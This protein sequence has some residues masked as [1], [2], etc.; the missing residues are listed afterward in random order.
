MTTGTRVAFATALAVGLALAAA[1]ALRG[2]G[3]GAALAAL[4]AELAQERQARERLE[5]EVARLAGDLAAFRE[6]ASIGD[7]AA[8]DRGGS[9]PRSGI[10]VDGGAAAEVA[11]SVEDAASVP[12]P[13]Y[14]GFDTDRLRGAGLA[15]RD[16]ADLRRLFE[17]IELDR[18]YL[19]NQASREG[20]PRERI[21]A[22]DAALD[23]RSA[24]V[25]Q[26]YGDETYDWFLYAAG[27]PNRVVVEGVLGGSAAEEA[28]IRRGD[29]ILSY[30]GGRVFR[31][32]PLVQ[33]T[34]RGSLD[35][36]VDVELL[37]GG[38][39][40]ELTLPRGPLGVRLGRRSAQPEP[41]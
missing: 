7:S 36:N 19:Q 10:D 20:W 18:L 3:D 37:R 16:V 13:G 12:S 1:L 22:E 39:R 28:G 40:I 26:T 6:G 24:T 34:I 17:E 14:A 32:G 41:Q 33:G 23:G 8:T 30:D 11:A 5:T 38:E 27:K 15:E 4:R 9:E 29:V 35:E 25:R 21:A 31:P 2:A